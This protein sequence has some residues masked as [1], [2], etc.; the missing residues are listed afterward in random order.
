M[1]CKQGDLA[2][3]VSSEAG[4][5]G[6]IVTVVRP[7]AFS[8]YCDFRHSDEGF[9]WWIRAEGSPILDTWGGKHREESFPDAWLRPIRPPAQDE[10]VTTGEGLG[11]AA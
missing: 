10:S 5:I 1:N 11:V 4:N 3:V 7:A 2:F 9:H 6:K 8:E